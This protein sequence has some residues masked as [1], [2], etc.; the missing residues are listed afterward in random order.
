M[1]C[2]K[3]IGFDAVGT[4]N[5][6]GQGLCPDCLSIFNPPL[7]DGC[8]ISH[9]QRVARSFWVQLIAMAFVFVFAMTI[10][11]ST[12]PVFTSILCSAVAAFSIPGWQFLSRY[13]PADGGYVDPTGRLFHIVMHAGLSLAIGIAVGP[14]YLY[15]AWQELKIIKA[16]KLAAEQR[17][18]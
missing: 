15:R 6:C 18:L 9:N 16:T 4:C 2:G 5:G 13:W 12:F 17:Q 7:C 8:A 3:H 14:V 11:A 1:K 10:F